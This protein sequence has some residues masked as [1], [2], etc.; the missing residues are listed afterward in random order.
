[1]EGELIAL[2]DSGDYEI[3]WL[4]EQKKVGNIPN[5][6]CSLAFELIKFYWPQERKTH[7]TFW[8]SWKSR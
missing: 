4:S 6:I 8:A 2:I 7:Q 3:L 1:M 5:S